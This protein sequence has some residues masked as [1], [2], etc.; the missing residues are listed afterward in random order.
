MKTY[1][2]KPKSQSKL[3]HHSHGQ[4]QSSIKSIYCELTLHKTNDLTHSRSVSPLNYKKYLGI[5]HVLTLS[6][7]IEQTQRYLLC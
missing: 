3:S 4:V 1:S 7:M 6:E 2:S 5:D